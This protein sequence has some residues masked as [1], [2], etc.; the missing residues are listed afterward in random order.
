M[1]VATAAATRAIAQVDPK[2][3]YKILIAIS[4]MASAN[5]L[6]VVA[7]RLSPDLEDRFLR[8]P[9]ARFLINPNALEAALDGTEPNNV[10]DPK[11]SGGIFLNANTAVLYTAMSSTMLW[12]LSESCFSTLE[13]S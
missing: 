4:I 3:I 9:V 10:S 7:F 13:P 5:S 6:L 1:F 12:Y 2:T 8:S 11:K